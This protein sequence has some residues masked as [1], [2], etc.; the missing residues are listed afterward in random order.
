MEDWKD[1]LGFEGVYQISNLGKLR[2]LDRIVERKSINNLSYTKT[3]KGTKLKP[4]DNGIGYL[5]VRLKFGNKLLRKYVHRLVYETF[6]TVLPEDKEINHIDH[7]KKNNSLSNL[8]VV[9][10]KENISLMRDFY[11]TSKIEHIK[12]ICCGNI[13]SNNG[14]NRCKICSGLSSRKVKDRPTKEVLNKLLEN[15]SFLKV[16]KMFNVSDNT[17]RKW[18]K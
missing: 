4:S 16:G 10:R 7:D 11:N 5:Q 3:I 13:K 2:S 9:T 8:E 1:I 15:N 17:I 12:C 14:S 18:L 6:V